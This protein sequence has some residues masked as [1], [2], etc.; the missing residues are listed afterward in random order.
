MLKVNVSPVFRSHCLYVPNLL[1][2]QK[3][4][5]SSAEQILDVWTLFDPEQK[6][7][8]LPGSQLWIGYNSKGALASVDHLHFHVGLVSELVQP[9]RTRLWI[10]DHWDAENESRLT[11]FTCQTHK[12][13][14]Q[15]V[16]GLIKVFRATVTV[17]EPEHSLKAKENCV[18]SVF[19]VLAAMKQLNICYNLTFLKHS[20]FI[21][22]RQNQSQLSEPDLLGPACVE[23]ATGM[24]L[25]KNADFFAQQ[26]QEL[27]LNTIE[28][29]LREEV[30]LPSTFSAESFF[31]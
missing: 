29:I 11:H 4:E 22:P 19:T 1:K 5:I 28:R 24:F 18:Q 27:V 15:T 17:T 25:T 14:S 7:M 16:A 2:L 23:L 21:F 9:G 12:V 3:Q 26:D 8:M 6:P 31:K 10:E 30:D 13:E 20:I